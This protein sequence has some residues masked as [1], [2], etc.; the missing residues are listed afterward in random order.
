MEIKKFKMG[1][2]WGLDGGYTE[3]RQNSGG[4]ELPWKTKTEMGGKC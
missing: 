4:R 1:R 2:A 3:R